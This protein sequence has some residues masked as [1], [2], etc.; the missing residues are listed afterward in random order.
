MASSSGGNLDSANS[1][2]SRNDTSGASAASSSGGV[3]GGGG[4]ATL[5]VRNS[6]NTSKGSPG[7][8]FG[9][10]SIALIAHVY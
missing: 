8:Y 3:G 9:S 4:A 5:D 1:S 6:F 7:S 10:V 2:F